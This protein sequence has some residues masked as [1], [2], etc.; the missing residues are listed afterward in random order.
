[1]ASRDD[2]LDTEDPI[3]CT[4]RSFLTTASALALV[5]RFLPG[6]P[7]N[8]IRIGLIGTGGRARGLIFGGIYGSTRQAIKGPAVVKRKKL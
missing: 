4:R 5:V 2:A 6:A 1:V 3:S 7:N 8:T